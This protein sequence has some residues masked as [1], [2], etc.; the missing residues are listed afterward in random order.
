M[1][2]LLT[3]A[4]VALLLTAALI[5]P[6]ALPGLVPF[7]D[8]PSEA[9]PSLLPRIEMTVAGHPSRPRRVGHLRGPPGFRGTSAK[10]RLLIEG[11][12]CDGIVWPES[13]SPT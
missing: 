3:L 9:P 4:L 13:F 11:G 8:W 1:R 12:P 7:V 10:P 6:G 2:K 5:L